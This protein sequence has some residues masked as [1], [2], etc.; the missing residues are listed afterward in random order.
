MWNHWRLGCESNPRTKVLQTY[1]ERF[2]VVEYKVVILKTKRARDHIGTTAVKLMSTRNYGA[3]C[4]VVARRLSPPVLAT[5]SHERSF[6]ALRCLNS[7]IAVRS[8]TACGASA[9]DV[10]LSAA[11]SKPRPANSRAPRRIMRRCSTSR[12]RCSSSR[13]SA[14]VAT[15]SLTA[16][17]MAST[18]ASACLGSSPAA[19]KLR[20]AV[21][22]SKVVIFLALDSRLAD[23][24][25]QRVCVKEAAILRMGG[26]LVWGGTRE[27]FCAP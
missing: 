8:L 27:G 21:S 3:D 5:T 18:M 24:R 12:R 11:N 17:R 26:W 20:A 9:Y 6:K 14:F 1:F 16:D 10:S 25:K 22:V 19:C 4:V 2:Y 13:R 23:V 15:C 7:G